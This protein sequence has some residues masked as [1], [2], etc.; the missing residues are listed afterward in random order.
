MIVGILG[1]G[2][3][4]SLCRLGLMVVAARAR[5]SGAEFDLVDLKQEFRHLHEPADYASPPPGSQTERLRRRVARA[6]GT[7]L[8]TPV[9]HGSFSGLLKNAL[10]HLQVG[11]FRHR[12]VGLVADD[13]GPDGLRDDVHRRVI[14][15]VD[16]LRFLGGLRDADSASGNSRLPQKRQC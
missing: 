10:D 16:E 7:V 4:D 14:A 9:Y 2:G 13:F 8:A 5:A 3:N 12:A 1:S 11:A 15:L 6:S